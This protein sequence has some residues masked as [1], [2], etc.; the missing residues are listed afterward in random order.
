MTSVLSA[1]YGFLG[2]ESSSP[3]HIRDTL[4]LL[5]DRKVRESQTKETEFDVT[6]LTKPELDTLFQ[7][8]I[9]ENS[10]LL[11]ILSRLLMYKSYSSSAERGR[12]KL[13]SG[14]EEKNT[15]PSKIGTI[16]TRLYNNELQPSPLYTEKLVNSTG[17]KNYGNINIERWHSPRKYLEFT[18]PTI[19]GVP[20]DALNPEQSAPK[21]IIR[22]VEVFTLLVLEEYFKI[23]K[24]E[25]ITDL[26]LL[27]T[28]HTLLEMLLIRIYK[29]PSKYSPLQS[30]IL[31]NLSCLD[32][33]SL[34]VMKYI[35]YS[36]LFEHNVTHLSRGLSKSMGTLHHGVFIENSITV[37]AKVWKL[38]RPEVLPNG[39][40][41]EKYEKGAS[42]GINSMYNFLLGAAAHDS[43][44]FMYDY[45]HSYSNTVLKL[46]SFWALGTFF[47]KLLRNSC[48]NLPPWVFQNYTGVCAYH[49]LITESEKIQTVTP[50]FINFWGSIMRDDSGWLESFGVVGDGQNP[51]IVRDRDSLHLRFAPSPVAK[52]ANKSP[53]R[54]R[55]ERKKTRKRA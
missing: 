42:V 39:R 17:F 25:V 40:V 27:T 6:L 1:L 44:V 54:N 37:E 34:R 9:N 3:L 5:L 50:G 49:E 4:Q 38:P 7:K 14:S 36:K 22:T 51:V 24:N 41:G 19:F 46:R 29:D 18:D 13:E 23:R 48:E 33:D 16:I 11:T 8:S 12:Y 53:R 10:G 20:R 2:S 55:C 47:Y 32:L 43:S 35:P 28:L 21:M 26:E 30:L 15:H 31:E 45:I 52:I